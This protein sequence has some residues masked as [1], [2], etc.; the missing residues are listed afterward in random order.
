MKQFLILFFLSAII[1]CKNK[2]THNISNGYLIEASIDQTLNGKKAY[3]KTQNNGVIIILDTTIIKNGKFEFKGNIEKP[4]IYGIQI[5]SIKGTIVMFMENETI[6]IEVYKDSLSASKISG[7]KT[8]DEYLDFVKRSNKIVS[9]MNVLFPVFQKARAENDV[10]KLQEINEKMQ[11]ISNDNT[12]F[13]LAYAKE[14]SDSYIGAMALQSV[15]RIPSIER[16]TISKIYNNFSDYVK[17]G[18]FAIET[19]LFLENPIKDD[20]IQH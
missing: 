3:L 1:S 5:D 17:R 9:R 8:N 20:T 11:K 6:T 13:T 15:I 16:D 14:H 10:E 7:S 18:E 2:S 4:V 19:L 12:V